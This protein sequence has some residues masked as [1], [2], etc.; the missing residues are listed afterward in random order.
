MRATLQDTVDLVLGPIG[1]PVTDAVAD[2]TKKHKMPMVAANSS[3]TAIYRK[4]RKFIFGI[5]VPAEGYLEGLIDLA[6][7]KGLKTVALIYRKGGA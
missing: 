5:L 4:G 3:A 1:S 2:V 6:A 7:K